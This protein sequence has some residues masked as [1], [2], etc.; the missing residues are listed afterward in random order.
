MRHKIIYGRTFV[1]A[2][3]V[4][5]LDMCCSKCYGRLFVCYLF[6]ICVRSGKCHIT[7]I[8][9]HFYAVG[10]NPWRHISKRK[11]IQVYARAFCF[12]KL[13][14]PDTHMCVMHG[15][16]LAP[17][18]PNTLLFDDRAHTAPSRNPDCDGHSSCAVLFA[19]VNGAARK[20]WTSRFILQH[21]VDFQ[22]K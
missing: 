12:A 13:P 20:P 15:T 22:F 6:E 3:L 21:S 9:V 4:M 7:D 8:T 1:D 11:S 5:R 10:S 17:F 2:R 19:M 16:L 14:L 18:T